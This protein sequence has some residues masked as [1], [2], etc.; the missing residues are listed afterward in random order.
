M[1]Q[2][3]REF[4][5]TTFALKNK[6][7]VYLLTLVIA[8]GGMLA[9]K[10]LPKE[11]FPEVV[12]PYV[13]VQTAYPGNNPADIENLV[14]RPLEKELDGI[15]GLKKLSSTSMQDVSLI[16][17]EF[18]FDT[19]I[20]DALQDVKDA[21]DKAKNDLP[22]DLPNDPQVQDLDLTEFPFI[23][24][25]VSGDYSIDQLKEYGDIM[26]EEFKGIKEVS[27][28]AVQGISEKEVRIDVDQRKLESFQMS[29]GDI[30]EAIAQENLS[31]GGGQVKINGTRR[32]VR[33]IGE[34]ENMDQIRNT[35]VKNEDGNIIYLKDVANVT[36]TYE[37]PESISRLGET[38]VIS[39]QVIKKSG[40]NLLSASEH[41]Y[42]T[43]DKIRKEHLVP[44][45]LE[46]IAT[47]DQSDMI[48]KQLNNLEN[49][50]I[51]SM[52]FVVV[53]LFFF[54]GT[55]NALFVGLAI[56]MSMFLSFMVLGFMGSKIN[57]M[58]LFGLILALGM[59]VD[60][61]IVVVENIYR[62]I[63]HGYKKIDAAR[64]AVGEVAIPIIAS[65]ATTLAAFF[66]LVFWDSLMGEFMYFLPITLIIVLTSSL[67]VALVLVPVVASSLIKEG[68][69][70]EIIN[71]KR[72]HR[73]MAIFLILSIPFYILG[74]YT[75][76]NLLFI[77][78]FV[79]FANVYIF[80]KLGH[81]FQDVFLVN[82][83]AWYLALLN[84]VIRGR[85]PNIIIISAF[86]LLIGTIQLL[87]LSE[88]D[89]VFFPESDPN[90]INIKTDLPIGTDIEETDAFMKQ[91]YQKVY[92]V[93]LPDSS[94]IKSIVTNVGTGAKTQD[95]MGGSIAEAYEGLIT[96]SF[97]DFEDRNGISSQKT[98]N[99]ISEAIINKYPGVKISISKERKG[100]PTGKPINLEIIGKDYNQLIR[101]TDTV[102][103]IIDNKHI[104]G[105]EGLN[106]DLD[107]GKPELLVHINR[108]EARR[109]GMSTGMI[110]SSIRTALFGKEISDY[111]DGE[112]EYPIQLR[113]RPDQRYN[114]P[115]LM[116]QKMTFR[117]KKGK[118]MQIP[119][120]AVADV[121]YNTTYGSIKRKDLDRVIT[122]YSNVLEGY[123]AN[124][125][126]TKLKEVLAE[127]GH[128]FG[129]GYKYKFTGEQEEQAESMAFL[130]T[131]MGIAVALI[132]I[133]LV[134]QFNSIVK[135]LIIASSIVLSTIGVFGGIATFGMDII[136]V[137]T[138][139]GIVSLAGVV[140]NNAIV[141]IDYIDLLKARKRVELGME[142]DAVLPLEDAIECIVK[143]GQTR[144]RPVL[145]TAI[146]TIL[147]L[148][149]MAV[150]MNINFET[151]LSEFNPQISFGGDMAAMWAPL[152]WTVIFGLTFATFL[153]LVIVPVIYKITTKWEVKIKTALGKV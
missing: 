25:N 137:M 105:I 19:K 75:L 82:L 70:K 44:E 145:L 43:I 84:Y 131:A 60:N 22:N 114:I 77:A 13:M 63:D 39:L 94:I 74:W 28:V 48:K 9:Y 103:S 14:T 3:V 130:I 40:E 15:K 72:A 78:A 113:L 92:E 89:I 87:K 109:F 135:P 126:N 69:E 118:I 150:G 53:V 35:I 64:L 5:L 81:W 71:K 65:T 111:K 133:I 51:I 132:L 33:I 88:P 4:K 26:E 91:L 10:S 7:S 122:I 152:S 140:V 23:N 58:V 96:I 110:A 12:I 18:T 90:Y 151:L 27:K 143:G 142:E 93:T 38:P 6:T 66:P 100:P 49:S 119:I 112:D 76:A 85:M 61:A 121:S 123:N 29:F 67:F 20:K 127:N 68:N 139:I 97:I 56:P 116:N 50:M 80:N 136:I 83:E 107:L 115:A 21:V 47:N 34:Y 125:I 147:G 86:L 30:E 62:F 41:V 16:S 95:N 8:I 124:E 138:G 42:Q 102:Q 2:K 99:H 32:A 141:L 59:L 24:I 36:Y 31:L 129:D 79:T 120:S 57:M 37:E 73:W 128:L 45:N 104:P 1:E 101:L 148:F 54:L 149:P 134:S 146:T 17:L 98:M 55:R 153:T 46:I 117:N 52:I 108:E 106:V 11:L 144:L